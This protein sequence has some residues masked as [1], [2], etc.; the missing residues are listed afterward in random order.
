MTTEQAMVAALEQTRVIAKQA[1]AVLKQTKKHH[2]SPTQIS[3]FRDCRRKWAISYID[4]IKSPQNAYAA[5][6]S[7]LHDRLEEYMTDGTLPPA[8]DEIAIAITKANGKVIEYTHNDILKIMLPAFKHLPAPGTGLCEQEFE[9]NLGELG[10][11]IGY[12]DLLYE[13][14]GV[15]V[16]NDYKSTGDFKWA[17][18]PEELGEDPQGV[19]YAVY[20]MEKAQVEVVR[21]QWIYIRRDAKRPGAKKVSAEIHLTDLDK[22]WRHIVE[23]VTE[24][25][26]LHDSGVKAADVEYD[27]T[28]CDK[29]GGCPHRSTV[30]K[31]TPMDRMRSLTAMLSLKER[32]LA[33]KQKTAEPTPTPAPEPEQVA[34]PPAAAVPAEGAGQAV[35]PPEGMSAL[36]KLKAKATGQAAPEPVPEKKVAVETVEPQPEPAKPKA[37]KVA[38]P[39]KA[40]KAA[41]QAVAPNNDGFTLYINCAPNKECLDFADLIAPTLAAIKEEHGCHYR[42]IDGLYG[43]NAALFAETLSQY[44]DASPPKADV[45]VTLASQEA[46]DA[47]EVLV[48]RAALVVRGQN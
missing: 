1:V 28:A 36:E 18:K 31:L 20:A 3:L 2:Y 42:L 23:D 27:A 8:T 6:G 7:Y 4:K 17:M 25:K 21:D 30:C 5:F 45:I 22:P 48:Q 9:L 46:R 12:I 24:M 29:Y 14:D 34:A 38:K 43:G 32:M 19:I 10:S 44:L 40:V 26:R 41:V 13:E 47:I 35:N 11:I 15:P 33:R 16:V 37:A 39:A